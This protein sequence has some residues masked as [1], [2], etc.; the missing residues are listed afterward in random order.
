MRPNTVHTVLTTGDSITHGWHCYSAATIRQSYYGIIHTF[1]SGSSLTNIDHMP[2]RGLIRVIFASWVKWYFGSRSS[3]EGVRKVVGPVDP[4]TRAIY[5]EFLA[6]PTSHVPDI[7]SMEGFLDM[8]SLGNLIQLAQTLDLR[9]YAGKGALS[10]QE[11]KPQTVAVQ[12]YKDFMEGFLKEYEILISEEVEP[13]PRKF[14]FE[15]SQHR[16]FCK[17]FMNFA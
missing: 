3:T 12:F 14:V 10:S 16:I 13:N 17:H 11:A 5:D 4:A 2:S 9:T 15:V 7:T 8:L 1:M 6:R